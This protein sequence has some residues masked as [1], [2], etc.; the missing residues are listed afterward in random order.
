MGTS[1]EHAKAAE[2]SAV[3]VRTRKRRTVQEKL[4]IVRETLHAQASGRRVVGY[5][6]WEGIQRL[7]PATRGWTVLEAPE[8]IQYFRSEM[9]HGFLAD[10]KNIPERQLIPIAWTLDPSRQYQLWSLCDMSIT[11][12]ATAHSRRGRVQHDH[13]FC[14]HVGTLCRRR[15]VISNTAARNRQSAHWIRRELK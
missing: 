11:C 12:T 8:V 5:A 2:T 7:S 9:D 13:F 6:R 3:G 1:V 10:V 14:R 4:R 15:L